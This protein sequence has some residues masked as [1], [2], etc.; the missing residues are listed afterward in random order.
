M[1]TVRPLSALLDDCPADSDTENGVE[2]ISSVA[3]VPSL[4][5]RVTVWLSP[6]VSWKVDDAPVFKAMVTEVP[7]EAVETAV[8]FDE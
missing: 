8:V 2:A 4:S 1:V 6:P 7:T 3:V 5:L